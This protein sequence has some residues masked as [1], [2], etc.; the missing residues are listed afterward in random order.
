MDVNTSF[1]LPNAGT[2]PQKARSAP[3]AP[4][5]P[6]PTVEVNSPE[7]VVRTSSNPQITQGA[8]QFSRQATYDQPSGRS[9]QALASYQSFEREEKRTELRNMLG[10]DIFA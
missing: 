3:D 1:I 7:G 6:A 8:D 5:K 9:Q 10:V 4:S 2:A